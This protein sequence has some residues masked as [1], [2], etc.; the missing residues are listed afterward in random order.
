MPQQ[1]FTVEEEDLKLSGVVKLFSILLVEE[2][3]E[4]GRN[5]EKKRMFEL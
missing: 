2:E 1:D 5:E 4:K 3:E